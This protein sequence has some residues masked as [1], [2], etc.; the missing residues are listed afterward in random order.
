M[1]LDTLDGRFQN[2][3]T[4]FGE[5]GVP[6]GTP[7][8][9]WQIRTDQD[10]GFPT[11]FT[12]QIN[13]DTNT[14]E[15]SCEIFANAP[16]SFDFNPAIVA[17]EAGTIFVTWSSTDPGMGFNAQV[18]I[19]GKLSGD[20]CTV[21]QTGSLV[22]QSANPLNGNFDSDVGAQRWGDYSAVTLDPA[23]HTIVW[24]MNEK[25]LAGPSPTTWKSYIFNMHN[26]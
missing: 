12:Y 10:G 1:C 26:P 13:A 19:T 16:G 9:F 7:V 20:M 24:G 21:A 22:N 15:E 2:A 17:N 18:R 3:G 25:V 6:G 23:D 5:P 4:Q 14:V 8:R 11:P